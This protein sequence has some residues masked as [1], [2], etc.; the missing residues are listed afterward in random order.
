MIDPAVIGLRWV[1]YLAALVAHGLPL[2]HLYGLRDLTPQPATRFA[3]V[4]GV[5]L[6][7]GALGGVI[8]QTAMMAGDWAAGLDL[9]SLS[10]VVQSTN[11][12]K[13]HVVRAGLAFSGVV[14][15]LTSSQHGLGSIFA[16]LAFA[17]AVATFA[18]SGHGAA[19]EGAAGLVHLVSDIVHLLAAALWLGALAGF[20]LL[21]TGPRKS[22]IRRMARALAEFSAIGTGAV[23]VLVVT[24][25]LNAGFLVGADGLGLIMGSSWGVLLIAKL[26]LFTLMLGLAAHNR[27]NL[28]PALSR[29]VEGGAAT[30]DPIQRLKV[31]VG[32]EMLAGAALLGLVAAIGVQ[33]PPTSM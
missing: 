14:A 12:G 32:L 33:M 15:L 2:F 21:L 26:L 28:T 20:C 16:I 22:E 8:V 17:G 1:Q 18:W 24:G 9:A 11:L 7:A 29:A 13:A 4:A 30:H 6:A 25:L 10:Y 3:A 31:S 19:S 27:F 23:T 5:A